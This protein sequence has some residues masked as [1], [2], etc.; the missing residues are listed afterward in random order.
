MPLNK[1]TRSH[2]RSGVQ[3]VVV[4]SCA[5][6]HT[7][8][9]R[10]SALQNVLDRTC[11]VCV[12]SGICARADRSKLKRRPV[13]GID[14]TVGALDPKVPMMNFKANRRDPSN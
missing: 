12:C 1:C 14:R 8:E 11:A 10:S 3:N 7:V 5:Q 2:S 13:F 4:C 9:V 6:G